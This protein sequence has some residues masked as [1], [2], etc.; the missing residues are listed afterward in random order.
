MAWAKSPRSE[1]ALPSH[2]EPSWFRLENG[3]EYIISDA[4]IKQGLP[5]RISTDQLN[6]EID[7]QRIQAHLLE[8]MLHDIVEESTLL[9]YPDK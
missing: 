9:E 5:T 8:G 3:S 7:E 2:K 6:P 1:A 4:D